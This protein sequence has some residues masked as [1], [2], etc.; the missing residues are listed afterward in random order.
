M[1]LLSSIRVLNET[2]AG[3]VDEA[4]LHGMH[5]SLEKQEEALAAAFA[6]KDMDKVKTLFEKFDKENLDHLKKEEEVMMS[7]VMQMKKDGHPMKKIMIQDVLSLVVDSE[8]FE[9]FVKFANEMLE[10]HSEGQPR[11]RV[12]DHALWAVATKEQWTVWDAWIKETVK[13][14]TYTTKLDVTELGS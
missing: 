14:E 4:G 11:V 2:Y 5:E 3:C 1:T 7:K 13:P 10:K 6:E 12:F 8:D 9:F